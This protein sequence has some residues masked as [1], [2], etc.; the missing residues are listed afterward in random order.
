M[1]QPR[2]GVYAA[3]AVQLPGAQRANVGELAGARWPTRAG[4]WTVASA[5][6]CNDQGALVTGTVVALTEEA[7]I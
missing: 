4:M 3:A 2:Y 5:C 6:G 7:D 1:P